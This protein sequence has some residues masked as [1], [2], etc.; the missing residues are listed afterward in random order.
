MPRSLPRLAVSVLLL[1][2][3]ACGGAGAPPDEGRPAAGC[4]ARATS[5]WAP[6]GSYAATASYGAEDGPDWLQSVSGIAAADSLVFVFDA[7]RSRVVVLSP[8]LAARGAFGRKGGGPGE[9][10]PTMGQVL[11]RADLGWIDAEGDSLLVFDGERLA[12]LSPRGEPIR[13][14]RR[15]RG[16]RL[17][18]N[19]ARQ[20]RLY[21]T[22]VL[23]ASEGRRGPGARE[24][25]AWRASPR[26]ETRLLSLRLPPLPVEGGAVVDGPDQARP[27]WDAGAGC[28]AASDGEGS[29]I[30][31]VPLA[32]GR[33]DTLPVPLPAAD[34]GAADRDADTEQLRTATRGRIR[35]IPPPSAVR[36]VE[37]LRVD[38][39]GWA[40]ILPRRPKRAGAGVDVVLVS[41]ATGEARAATVPAFPRAFGTPGSFYA[42]VSGEMDEHRVV[43]YS[44]GAARS[45]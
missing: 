23:F 38:P 24:W 12:L 33:P 37:A 31:R 43:R 13:Y 25:A 5:R 35:E 4:E 21:R 14:L 3:A 40:W 41:L 29:W 7:P 34:A 19:E 39:D 28:L 17:L 10:D 15:E 9:F 11:D 20:V 44:L 18:S 45:P 26:A 8:G 27:L 30:V 6:G 2:A 16:L 1:V 42:S 32:G 22:S 36:Q